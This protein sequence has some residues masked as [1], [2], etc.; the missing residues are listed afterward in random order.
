MPLDKSLQYIFRIGSDNQHRLHWNG[1]SWRYEF[2]AGGVLFDE[3]KAATESELADVI[4]FHGLRLDQFVVD[5]TNAGEAYSAR[6]NEKMAR[7]VA[8]GVSPCPKHGLTAK[9]EAGVCEACADPDFFDD[10][11][12]TEG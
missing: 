2:L 8:A 3:Q 10:F 12:G 6:V 11:K 1:S 9:N 5:T 4:G 7:L